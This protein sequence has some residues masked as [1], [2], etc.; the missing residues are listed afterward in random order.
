MSM[1]PALRLTQ[2]A[3]APVRGLTEILLLRPGPYARAF[4]NLILA[5]IVLSV[6]SIG[7]EAI[8]GLPDWAT[9]A[10]RIEEIVVVETVGMALQSAFEHL[11]VGDEPKPRA[12][13]IATNV[14]LRTPSGWRMVMH[15]A[16]AAPTL[17]SVAP[18]GPLH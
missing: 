13:A 10:L 5:L 15:H 14:F 3:T 2:A 12:T 18:A 6:A 11:S 4:D 1:A 7:V 8:P 17:A 9:R 16:S